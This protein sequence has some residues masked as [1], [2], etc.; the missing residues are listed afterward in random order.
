MIVNPSR[1]CRLLCLALLGTTPLAAQVL[2][3]AIEIRSLRAAEAE[4]GRPV[5]IAGVVVFV[6]SASAI[7][8]QDDTSTTFFRTRQAPLP[9]VGDAIELEGKT[10][11]GLYLPGIDYATY[12]IVGR[13]EVPAGIP[14][15]YDDLVFG[16]YHY[17]R[18][19]VDGVVR[20]VSPVEPRKSVIRLAI[21]S[22]VVEARVEQPPLDE[23]SLVDHRVRITGLAAGFLNRPRRQLVQPYLRVLDWSEVHVLAPAPAVADIPRISAAE[24]LAFHVAGHG[25]QRVHLEGV[26]TAVLAPDEIFLRQ[27]NLGFAVRTTRAARVDLGDRV[28]IVGFPQMGEFSASVVDAA[29]VRRESGPPPEPEA[30]A[31]L[32]KLDESHDGRLLRVLGTVR[33]A[34]KIGDGAAVLISDAT[35][36]LQVRLPDH[37]V[38]PAHGAQIAATGIYQVESARGS[39]EYQSTPELVSLRIRSAADLAVLR[40]PPWWTARRLA[41]VLA[42]FG[43]VIALGGLWIA[44]LR[45]Q[46]RRQTEALRHRIEAEAALEE[47]HRLA[48]E[49]HDTLEQEL[50]GVSLRLDALATRELDEK[51]RGLVRA[52]RNL[53]SRI[54]TETRDLISDLRDPAKTSGDLTAALAAE[55]A[56]LSA[57]TGAEVRL[58]PAR[59]IPALP[60]P[61]VHDLRMIAREATTNALK[62]GRATHVSLQT[63]ADARQ[64]VLRITDNGC[65]FDATTA[66]RQKH[67]HFGCE[68]MRERARKIGATVTWQSVLQKGTTVE[69]VLALPTGAGPDVAIASSSRLGEPAPPVLAGAKDREG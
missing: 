60:P 58:E 62:H 34:F 16:R 59:A 31:S 10:R 12:R 38:P 69:V 18:V 28:E 35:R 45:R 50:A 40:P 6:E 7:F 61:T 32:D 66:G 4:A 29:V 21:G 39:G 26:V 52:S 14:V 3:K 57:D 47:R 55:A 46:V 53:V 56:R 13:R 33:D 54:Q 5:R 30:V 44:A 49:F 41:T 15:Q 22:H 43:G 65:G 64:L 9:N 68:G 48:R 37:V 20:S 23:S 51:G 27:D 2:T 67:G 19:T 42:L 36:T 1:L 63:E 24:L 8:V 11:M 25:Q 17:Q